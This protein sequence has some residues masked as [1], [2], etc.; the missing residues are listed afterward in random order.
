M[1]RIPQCPDSLLTDGG[2]SVSPTHRPR[3]PPQKH[4]FLASGT[5]FCKRLSK[6][7]DLVRPEELG[8]MKKCIN[9]FESGTRDLPAC[10]IVPKPLR[11]RVPLCTMGHVI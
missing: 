11:C 6:P 10:G 5:Q 2:K 8:E 3:S 4:Y 9:L 1:L 7:Q